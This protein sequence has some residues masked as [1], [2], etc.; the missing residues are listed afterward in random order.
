MRKYFVL[1]AGLA[2]TFALRA[3]DFKRFYPANPGERIV[4]LTALP[5]GG[6]WLKS[7]VEKGGG[8]VNRVLVPS[9]HRVYRIP[10]G[11]TPLAA[12][13]ESGILLQ[14]G[15]KLYFRSLV[16]AGIFV[17]YEFTKG[18]PEIYAGIE[19]STSLG[20]LSLA[21]QNNESWCKAVISGMG[22]SSDRKCMPNPSASNDAIYGSRN[23]FGFAS[24]KY[25][26]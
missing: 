22:I 25:L 11:L 18:Y 21:Y 23:N 10:D 6:L 7:Q 15:E 20:L 9:M 19:T 5:G 17:S 14:Q 4:S 13:A 16:K 26:G 8:E 24:E 1:I 2:L 12:A 3:G